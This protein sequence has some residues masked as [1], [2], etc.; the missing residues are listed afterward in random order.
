MSDPSEVIGGV[1]GLMA[2]EHGGV[3]KKGKGKSREPVRARCHELTYSP[4]ASPRAILAKSSMS[5]LVSL[6][7]L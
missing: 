7:T 3:K 4:C 6:E 1:V 2:E 5:R